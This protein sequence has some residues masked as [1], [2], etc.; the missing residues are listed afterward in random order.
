[1]AR[2]ADHLHD[3]NAIDAVHFTASM[4]FA[5]AEPTLRRRRRDARFP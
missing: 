1:M 2:V 5:G 3:P 4:P